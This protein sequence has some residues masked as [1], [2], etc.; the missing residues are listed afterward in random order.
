MSESYLGAFGLKA[1]P[2]SKEIADAELWLPSSKAGVRIPAKP[3]GRSG[4]CR[5]PVPA[6]VIT[7]GVTP[8]GSSTSPASGPWS[9]LPSSS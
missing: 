9:S 5:S 8:L 1:A 3:I 6:K 2:F 7:R 4:R